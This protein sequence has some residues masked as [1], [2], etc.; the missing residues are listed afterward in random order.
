MELLDRPTDEQ[1]AALAQYEEESQIELAESVASGIQSLD[2][3]VETGDVPEESAQQVMDRINKAIESHCRALKKL[4]ASC[5]DDPWMEHADYKKNALADLDLCCKQL[6][7]AKCKHVCPD[8]EGAGCK[9]CLETGRMPDH[10]YK[11]MA[12]Q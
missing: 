3:A 5:P 9:H 11:Q 12:I 8:C 10:R 1:L 2:Q 6:R 4:F 7:L